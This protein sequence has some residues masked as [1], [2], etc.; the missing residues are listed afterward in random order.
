L[1]RQ[2][3]FLTAINAVNP[4]SVALGLIKAAWNH[5]NGTPFHLR[6]SNTS[7]HRHNIETRIIIDD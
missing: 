2:R 3:R 5:P 7:A 6:L 1:K 4:K